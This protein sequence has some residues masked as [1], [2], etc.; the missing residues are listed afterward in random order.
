MHWAHKVY[1]AKR[2]F[3]N[4]GAKHHRVQVRLSP[5]CSVLNAEVMYVFQRQPLDKKIASS[6]NIS[7]RS[8][9]MPHL[10]FVYITHTDIPLN[11]C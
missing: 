8:G 4:P 7:G 6:S 11:Y 10:S 1:A 2:S 5:Q 9:C 3:Q